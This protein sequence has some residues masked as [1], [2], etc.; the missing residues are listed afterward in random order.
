MEL[1]EADASGRRSPVPLPGSEYRLPCDFA[2]S[3]IGQDVDLCGLQKDPLLKSTRHNTLVFSENTFETSLPGVFTGGDMATGPAVAI[4]AIAHGKIA[5]N[6]ID[7]FVRSGKAAGK[8]KEFIS[9]KEA[10]GEIPDSDFADFARI[11]KEK[12]PVL[13][14]AARAA[15]RR[16][17]W[18]SAP[19]RR[20]T[21]RAA[22]WSAA[23]RPFST[24]TCA[25]TPSTS[26]WT[27]RSSSARSGNTRWT[28]PTPSR[29]RP[30]Q[31]HAL[32]PLRA[33]LF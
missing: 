28:R 26:A 2:I 24:A 3:A 6:A 7:H 23:A 33:H 19:S 8:E 5:A 11:R 1:G 14:P 32:R 31:V 30:Q 22:A 12:M 15:S 10:F 4:D 13:P 18:A 20:R 9:R 17:S 27:S 21:R 16:S 25:S 29:P